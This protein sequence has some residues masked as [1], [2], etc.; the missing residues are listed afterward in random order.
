[1]SLDAVLRWLNP[2]TGFHDAVKQ[3]G[4]ELQAK[5]AQAAPPPAWLQYLVF[6]AG[7][8]ASPLIR[9][10]RTTGQWPDITQKYF[11]GSVVFSLLTGFVV[12]PKVMSSLASPDA[13]WFVRLSTIFTAGLGWEQ[14]S[15]LP[16]ALLP[17]APPTT[18]H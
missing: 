17:A 1:M 5:V 7:V 10:Y 18:G 14:V 4:P 11:V 6:S 9:Q 16:S 12:F 15:G 3:A 8:F 13:G 2:N